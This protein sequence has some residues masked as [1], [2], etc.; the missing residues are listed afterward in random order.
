MR[1]VA[2]VLGAVLVAA[3][4]PAGAQ[5]APEGPSAAA[6]RQAATANKLPVDSI[7]EVPVTLPP[8]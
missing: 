4:V 1:T 6:I 5:S 3:S 2:A 7:T 8:K